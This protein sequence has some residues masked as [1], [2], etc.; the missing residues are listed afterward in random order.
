[1]KS[2]SFSRLTVFISIC[3]WYSTH[4][5]R[6]WCAALWGLYHT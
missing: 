3:C 1:M 6:G 4:W 2:S 5:T